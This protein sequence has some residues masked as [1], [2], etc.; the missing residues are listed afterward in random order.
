MQPPD[1]L[2]RLCAEQLG[3]ITRAQVMQRLT[4]HRADD[5]LRSGRFE[6]VHYGVYLL[7]GGAVSPF[8]PAVAATL[9]A[10]R[11]ATLTGPAALNLGSVAGPDTGHPDRRFGILMPR[12][13][14]VLA[15]DL[16]LLRDADPGRQVQ[17]R[18]DVRIADPV[19]ALLDT[20]AHFPSSAR[21]LR[22]WHD[23][24]RWKGLL[25]PGLLT[26]RAEQLGL[27]GSLLGSELLAM[28]ATAATG[29]GERAL[30]DLMRRFDPPPEPQVWVTPHRC[31]DLLFRVLGVALEY[32]GRAD[33]DTLSGRSSDRARDDELAM[34][35]IRVLYV[36][37]ED[38]LTPRLLLTRAAAALTARAHELGLPAPRLLGS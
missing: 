22:Q 10:G 17:H 13:R 12:G 28:D 27:T 20:G 4:E 29:D 31:V 33:H 15:K 23:R 9:R 2:L 7:R 16:P 8:R 30:G 24:L 5:L 38:L 18:G 32:Q 11:G 3:V 6:R 36:T 34:A 21:D 1:E 37:A 25:R 14:R 35:G 26:E 19:D